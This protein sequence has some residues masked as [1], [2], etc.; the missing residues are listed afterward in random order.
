MDTGRQASILTPHP[1]TQ[2]SGFACIFPRFSKADC[3]IPLK[4]Y[5]DNIEHISSNQSK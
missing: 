1:F 5:S 4:F 2:S 3:N